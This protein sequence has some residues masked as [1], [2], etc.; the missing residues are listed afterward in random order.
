MIIS[1]SFRSKSK[2]FGSLSFT[3]RFVTTRA[4][5]TY[6]S[7]INKWDNLKKSWTLLNRKIG[8]S[9]T[10]LKSC[11]Y[12]IQIEKNL[13]SKNKSCVKLIREKV[14]NFR[15]APHKTFFLNQIQVYTQEIQFHQNNIRE[16]KIDIMDE[17]VEFKEDKEIYQNVTNQMKELYSQENSLHLI[18]SVS[19]HPL[20]RPEESSFYMHSVE[21]FNLIE[22]FGQLFI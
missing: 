21:S 12:E 10:L 3:Q 2:K 17:L 19:N 8:E 15:N 20:V 6:N 22:L 9:S 18:E 11:Q 14:L 1:L 5:K 16:W 13:I 4:G 7:S